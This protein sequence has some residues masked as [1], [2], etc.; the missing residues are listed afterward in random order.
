MKKI[1]NKNVQP[2]P[3]NLSYFAF[4]G[5]THTFATTTLWQA[6]KC[7]ATGKCL[8]DSSR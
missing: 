3:V 6:Y 4:A 1:K 8:Y 5:K 7:W 2:H